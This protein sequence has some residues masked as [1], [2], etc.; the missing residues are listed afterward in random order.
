VRKRWA[1]S[2]RATRGVDLDYLLAG[3]SYPV[4]I[5][6]KWLLA[7]RLVCQV[8][9]AIEAEADPTLAEP[10]PKKAAPSKAEQIKKR[11]S[12]RPRATTEDRGSERNDG[13]SL[14][15]LLKEQGEV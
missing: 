6:T 8:V 9:L 3:G 1:E 11:L 4:Q 13:E 10:P 15:E 2:L 14:A 5:M 7:L 12:L